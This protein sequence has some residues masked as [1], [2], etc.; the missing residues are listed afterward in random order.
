M[1]CDFSLSII[2]NSDIVVC[3]IGNICQV[4]VDGN[5]IGAGSA[6]YFGIL[7]HFSNLVASFQF[8]GYLVCSKVDGEHTHGLIHI[9][10]TNTGYDFPINNSAIS[11]LRCVVTEWMM[12]DNHAIVIIR[13]HA[14]NE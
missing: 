11:G 2:N 9:G 7:N 12:V 6:Y 1:P 10:I 3:S 5:A 13:C 14:F 4:T 8:G